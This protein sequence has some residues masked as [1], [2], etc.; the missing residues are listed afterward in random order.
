[1]AFKIMLSPATERYLAQVRAEMARLHELSDR[2]LAEEVLRLARRARE[3]FPDMLG[4]TT[5]EGYDTELVWRVIPEIGRRLGV[6][7]FQPN[8]APHPHV[9]HLSDLD[10]RVYAASCIAGWSLDRAS[11]EALPNALT[12]SILL[13]HE[14]CNGNPVGMLM[15]R[16]CEPAPSRS[17]QEDGV[18]RIIREVSRVRGHEETAKWSP[19]LNKKPTPKEADP[20]ASLTE[21]VNRYLNR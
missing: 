5:A 15:D 6:T 1:M 2:W 7:R 18:A 13:G 17:K 20:A 9:S 8:E 12:A 16:L 10:L 14:P 3:E 4:N 19:E 21:Q 11:R